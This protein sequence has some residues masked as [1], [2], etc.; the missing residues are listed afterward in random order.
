VRALCVILAALVALPVGSWLNL[1]IA[2]LPI[3]T[4]SERVPLRLPAACEA[5]QSP[6]RASQ[7]FAPMRWLS[8]TRCRECD[9]AISRR[10]VGVEL[11]TMAV[12]AVLAAR[13]GW[14]WELPAFLVWG[15]ALV[16]VSTIDLQLFRI[17]DRIVFPALGAGAVL[18]GIAAIGD[19]APRP[20]VRAIAGA[21]IYFTILLVFHLVSPRGMGFGDVKLALL[22]GLFVGWVSLYLIVLALP[23]AGVIGL[24]IGVPLAVAA[25]DRKRPFPFGPAL[26]AGAVIVVLFASHLV[27]GSV[28]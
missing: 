21:A 12:W 26:C 17:P 14:S 6:R 28:R 18:L 8:S 16:V 27:T 10:E 19:S 5:C 4:R 1:L 22:L 24:A 9:T 13:F 20:F 7:R 2:R 11:V 15:A 25:R 3:K 23:A